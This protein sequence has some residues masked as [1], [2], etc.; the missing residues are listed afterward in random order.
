[1]LEGVTQFDVGR[2]D[3][4]WCWK[5]YSIWC[6]KELLSLML[7]GVAQFG[8]AWAGGLSKAECE[9]NSKAFFPH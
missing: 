7:E 1:M 2:N 3:S 9:E 4:V 5:E 6:W 8:V